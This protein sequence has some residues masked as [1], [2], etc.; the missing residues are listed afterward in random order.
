MMIFLCR[1]LLLK[2]LRKLLMLLETALSFFLLCCLFHNKM[3][4]RFIQKLLNHWLSLRNIQIYLKTGKLHLLL[5][6]RLQKQ[7]ACRLK[8]ARS[9][10]RMETLTMRMEKSSIQRHRRSIME[11]KEARKRQL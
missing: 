5:N 3:S 7:E 8:K 9:L 2:K 1:V 10:L 4:C 11:R 6:L